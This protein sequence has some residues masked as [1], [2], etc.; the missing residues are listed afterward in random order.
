MTPER[1]FLHLWESAGLMVKESGN[2]D[3]MLPEGTGPLGWRHCPLLSQLHPFPSTDLQPV[4]K[5][6]EVRAP[7]RETSHKRKSQWQ[8][9]LGEKLWSKDG[10]SLIVLSSNVIWKRSL[11]S[12]LPTGLIIVRFSS[13]LVPSSPHLIFLL[14][15]YFSYFKTNSR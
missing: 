13:D 8:G 15:Y 14:V 11:C 1:S 6:T 3:Q 2:E 10:V 5:N 7:M 9:R 4:G 12:Y